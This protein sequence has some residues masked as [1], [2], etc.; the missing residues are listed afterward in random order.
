MLCL[1]HDTII[2]IIIWQRKVSSSSYVYTYDLSV[3]IHLF[4]EAP[5]AAE[6]AK[7]EL[8]PIQK[9]YYRRLLT[10]D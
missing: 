2:I 9:S 4:A 10:T 3:F 1:P 5:A 6:A 8:T 7:K